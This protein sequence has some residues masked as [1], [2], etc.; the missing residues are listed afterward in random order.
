M[1]ENEVKNTGPANLLTGMKA[2][3]YDDDDDDDDGDEDDGNK[4]ECDKIVSSNFA[5][6]GT[7]QTS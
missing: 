2:F 4:R 3:V 7:C 1:V 5:M 6:M